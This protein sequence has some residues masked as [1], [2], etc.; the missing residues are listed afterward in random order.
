MEAKT[1]K[2]RTDSKKQKKEPVYDYARFVRENW[3]E[4]KNEAQSKEMIHK[5]AS[6]LVQKKWESTDKTT[7]VK[8]TASKKQKKKPVYDYARFVR[9]NWA[10]AKKEAE[11]NIM[12]NTCAM[13]LIHKKWENADKNRYVK[14]RA[15]RK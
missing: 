7:Y 2:K 4:A 5:C 9:E 12:T 6:I 1:S 10:E 8:T 13:L 14:S 15:A 11:S 3:A